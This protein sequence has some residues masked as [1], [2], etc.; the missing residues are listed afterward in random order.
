MDAQQDAGEKE[1][2]T[3]LFYRYQSDEYK[4]HDGLQEPWGYNVASHAEVSAF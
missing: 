2:Q 3:P 1:A 4:L